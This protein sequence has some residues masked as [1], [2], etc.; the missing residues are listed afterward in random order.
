MRRRW[1]NSLTACAAAGLLAA[2]VLEVRADSRDPAHDQDS[3]MPLTQQVRTGWTLLPPERAEERV[4]GY[5]AGY[6]GREEREARPL[7]QSV[8]TG[9][10]I[11]R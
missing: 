8:R 3:A 2:G 9:Y 1:L 10:L 7:T 4:A 5:R 11:V 6:G